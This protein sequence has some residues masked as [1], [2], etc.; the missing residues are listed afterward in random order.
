MTRFTFI[1]LLAIPCVAQIHTLQVYS[2]FTRVDPFGNIVKQ[3]KGAGEPRHILSP[4]VPRNAFS[5]LRIAVNLDKPTKY[6]L[7]IGQNPENAVKATL[8]KERFEKHGDQWI[9]DG[10]EPVKIPYESTFPDR[11]DIPGQTVVT[12][13]LDMWV[14]KN[15]EVDRIK[16]EPQLWVGYQD[17]WV[18]YP[19][20]VR[21]LNAVIPDLKF[22]AAA[23]PEVQRRSD[24]TVQGPLQATLCGSAERSGTA[25]INARAMIRRNAL[26]FMALP[27]PAVIEKLLKVS[28]APTIQSWCASTKPESFGPEWFL[29]F[30]D[31]LVQTPEH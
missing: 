5:S 3:D 11:D 6:I 25:A 16:V 21:I 17:D 9:P 26:Q 23:L 1:L 28:K 8:Y 27:K 29:R 12:F 31:S 10:L 24:A 22:S 4:G 19:M 15:A 7:D 18:T 30:R 13:W 2:E 20:E 14:A